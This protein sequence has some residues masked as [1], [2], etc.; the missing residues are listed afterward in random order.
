M[1]RSSKTKLNGGTKTDRAES[2]KTPLLP[3]SIGRSGEVTALSRSTS[4]SEKRGRSE[5]TPE[6]PKPPPRRPV[7]LF[8]CL[9]RAFYPE[10]LYSSFIRICGDCVQFANPV[11]L[12]VLIDYTENKDKYPEWV[13]YTLVA[14]FFA[15]TF[16]ISV[17]LNQN[18]YF[19]SNIGMKI[20]TA[21][22]ATVY[23]KTLH[24]SNEAKRQYTS[25]A[26]VNLMAVDCQKMQSVTAQLWVLLS[27]PL[28]I[29][30]AFYFLNDKLGA[31]FLVGVAIILLQI[32]LNIR[33][34]VAARRYQARQLGLKDQR[35]KLISEVLSGM[36][37][38]FLTVLQLA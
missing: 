23:K 9:F 32:P 36:K 33:V 37:C 14:G 1:T 35:L 16:I 6:R 18:F 17:C 13:G 21:L 26:I 7:P 38:P 22:V 30:L 20:K 34:S 12:N 31:S 27:A 15:V 29:C 2:E 11:I 25:G 19:A 28:Q 5:S 8:R 24:M 3:R 10:L 4:R